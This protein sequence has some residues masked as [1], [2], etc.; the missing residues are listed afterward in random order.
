MNK[1]LDRLELTDDERSFVDINNDIGFEIY[2][3]LLRT[4]TWDQSYMT[5]SC[6]NYDKPMLLVPAI[7]FILSRTKKNQKK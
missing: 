7:L 5:S 1:K 3:K 6:C 4:E 2:K